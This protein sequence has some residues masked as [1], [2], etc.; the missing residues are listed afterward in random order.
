MEN[1]EN[2]ENWWINNK[3]II[4][5]NQVE[6]GRSNEQGKH[7]KG[8]CSLNKMSCFVR[9]LKTINAVLEKNMNIL[10]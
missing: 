6:K 1:I 4:T 9:Y 7:T 8:S 2:E 10:K 3:E 5:P